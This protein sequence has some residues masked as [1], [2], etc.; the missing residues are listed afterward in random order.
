MSGFFEL[1]LQSPTFPLAGLLHGLF[2]GLFL[3]AGPTR[4]GGASASEGD[5]D[6]M[7][8]DDFVYGEWQRSPERW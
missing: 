4:G 1:S 8:L 3:F 6:D 5:D 2:A 7:G